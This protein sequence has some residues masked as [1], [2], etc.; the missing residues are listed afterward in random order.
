MLSGDDCDCILEFSYIAAEVPN[1]RA[2]WNGVEYRPELALIEPTDIECRYAEWDGFHGAIGV[3]G[4]F[5][6]N[7]DLYVLPMTVSFQGIDMVEEPCNEVVPPTGYY[8]STN[9]NGELSHT[10]DAQ[11]GWWNHVKQ[12]NRW[13]LDNAFANVRYPPWSD[14]IMHW[15]IPVAWYQRFAGE[16][17]SWPRNSLEAVRR[18][19]AGSEL[20]LQ[21]FTMTENGTVSVGK[22]EHIISRT[23]NDVIRLD[24]VIVNH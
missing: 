23:T 4:G 5:G 20:Y 18:R 2:S 22:F 3:A 14:G 7:L 16:Q 24:G 11:A 1:L 6:M 21:I 15:K 19:M 13:T 17:Y 12:G 10:L 9:F 8:A